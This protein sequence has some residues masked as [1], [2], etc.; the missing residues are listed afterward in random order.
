MKYLSLTCKID[1]STYLYSQLGKLSL[2]YRLLL[3]MR[4]LRGRL[5][6]R[7]RGHVVVVRARMVGAVAVA[8]R[9]EGYLLITWSWLLVSWLPV[10]SLKRQ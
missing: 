3:L 10:G 9:W 4:G 6:A 1:D 8:R 2:E 5:V 7:R